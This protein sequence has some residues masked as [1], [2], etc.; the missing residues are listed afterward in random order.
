MG[1]TSRQYLSEL[2]AGQKRNPSV[3]VLRKLAKALDVPVAR[4]LE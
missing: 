2:E 3:V 4:L 1:A